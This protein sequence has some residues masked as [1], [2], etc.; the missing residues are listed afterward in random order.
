MKKSFKYA[1]NCH[2][3]TGPRSSAKRRVATLQASANLLE[4]MCLSGH[5]IRDAKAAVPGGKAGR[6]GMQETIMYAAGL[7]NQRHGGTVALPW[8]VYLT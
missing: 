6:Q 1:E 5:C 8:H 7:R 3:Q 4:G 2:H